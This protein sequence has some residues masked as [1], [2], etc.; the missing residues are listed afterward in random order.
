MRKSLLIAAVAVLMGSGAW[1][2]VTQAAEDHGAPG[3]GAVD[4][5][6]A[7][8]RTTAQPAA[9]AHPTTATSA[10]TSRASGTMAM[11]SD[12]NFS[13]SMYRTRT[14][15]LNAASAA[16]ASLSACNGVGKNQ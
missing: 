13:P 9:P 11:Q 16:H 5:V 8:M 7:V 15:C 10:K 14:D 2:Q 6:N 12:A 4:N 3:S 1:I